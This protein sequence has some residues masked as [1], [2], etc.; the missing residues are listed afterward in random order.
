MLNEVQLAGMRA[1]VIENKTLR[2]TVL[3][4]KGADII[5]FLY[6]PTNTDWMGISPMGLKNPKEVSG[7]AFIDRYEGGWQEVFPNGGDPC[8][9]KGVRYGQHGEAALLS[10]DYT[11]ELNSPEQVQVRLETHSQQHPLTFNK[12][13]TLA[14]DQSAL[15]INE[16]ITNHGAE[17]ISYMW[18]QHPAFGAPALNRH[19]RIL[20]PECRVHTQDEGSLGLSSGTPWP[21]APEDGADLSWVLPVK[22]QKERMYFLTGL[23]EGRYHIYDTQHRTGFRLSWCL[24]TYPYLWYWHNSGTLDYPWKGEAYLMALEPF[25]APVPQLSRAIAY[26]WAKEIAPGQTINTWVKA[27]ATFGEP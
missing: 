11:V 18:G 19:C 8:T 24:D 10:W 13:F 23:S 5:E 3:L 1:L 26:G 21:R 25:S 9:V 2:L 20:L 4:D 7:D 17:T 27:E 16:W 22:A 15:R 12:T 6:K 14:S